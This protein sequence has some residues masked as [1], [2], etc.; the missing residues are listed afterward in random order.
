MMSLSSIKVSFLWEAR[1]FHLQNFKMKVAC[2][3]Q[4]VEIGTR[5][6]S[7]EADLLKFVPNSEG[8]SYMTRGQ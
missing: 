2:F 7:S 5:V 6:V 3:I 1:D 4:K 8:T